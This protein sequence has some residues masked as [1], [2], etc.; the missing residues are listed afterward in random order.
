[1]M[2]AKYNRRMDFEFSVEAKMELR[3]WPGW[4]Y[5]L[6]VN[7]ESYVRPFDIFRARKPK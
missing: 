5:L 7:T 3:M 6:S 4:L 1:M 2:Q